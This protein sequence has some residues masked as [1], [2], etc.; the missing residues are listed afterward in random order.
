MNQLIN[1]ALQMIAN[2]PNITHNNPNANIQ[3]MIQVIQSGNQQEG[4]LIA[5]NLLESNGVSKEQGIQQAMQFFGLR[6]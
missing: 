2:N 4:E 5:K 1:W 3:H 6:N